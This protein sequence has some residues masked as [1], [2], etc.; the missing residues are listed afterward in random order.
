VKSGIRKYRGGVF[1]VAYWIDQFKLWV[2]LQKI[3]IGDILL[4]QQIL[5]KKNEE[6][7]EDD[8]NNYV[9]IEDDVK[10]ALVRFEKE[11]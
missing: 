11:V 2:L 9:D 3:K 5:T 7:D 8:L 4:R 10:R 6:E 1:K